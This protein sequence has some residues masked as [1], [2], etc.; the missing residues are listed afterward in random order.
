LI[1]FHTSYFRGISIGPHERD[2][3][4]WYAQFLGPYAGRTLPA[5]WRYPFEVSDWVEAW[6]EAIE[7]PWNPSLNTWEGWK[8]NIDRA[9]ALAPAIREKEYADML[10][11]TNFG[12]GSTAAVFRGNDPCADEAP[13]PCGF[14]E[15][16]CNCSDQTDNQANDAGNRQGGDASNR[17][18]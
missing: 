9:K 8:K 17:Q 15:R 2:V 16:H 5:N 6:N 7:E 12:V 18:G 11:V 3:Q 13:D 14:Q 10:L 4:I 1:G